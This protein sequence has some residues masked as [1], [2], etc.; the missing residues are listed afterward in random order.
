MPQ[1]DSAYSMKKFTIEVEMEEAWI[2]MFLDILRKYK[3][4]AGRKDAAF[5]CFGIEGEFNATFKWDE[6]L[7]KIQPRRETS[8]QE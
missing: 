4:L 1:I 2:P 6:S 3:D 5:L 7:N 8:I